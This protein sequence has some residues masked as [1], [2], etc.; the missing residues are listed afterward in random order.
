MTAERRPED[1]EEERG[2]IEE[3]SDC[4]TESGQSED[5]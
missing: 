2:G 1:E 3:E 4:E 5:T